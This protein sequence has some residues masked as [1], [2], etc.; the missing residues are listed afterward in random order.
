MK[1]AIAACAA[2][3]V[4]LTGCSGFNESRGRGDAPVG[5][6]DD[7]PAE[8]INYPDLFANIASKCD[9]HGHRVYVTTRDNSSPVILTDPGCPGG[10]G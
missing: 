4:L 2:A 7:T 1:R 8:V 10:I 9:H 3:G 6:V 5:Q